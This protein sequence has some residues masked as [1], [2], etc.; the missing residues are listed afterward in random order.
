MQ[1]LVTITFDHLECVEESD[2]NAGHS[3]PYLWA[4]AVALQ[5]FAVHAS[6]TTSAEDHRV[7]IGREVKKEDVV[8]IETATSQISM[9][10]EHFE[11][12]SAIALVSTILEEDRSSDEAMERG[13]RAYQAQLELELTS[14]LFL[15]LT[16][17]QLVIAALEGALVTTIA[18]GDAAKIKAEQTALDKKR[19]K[20]QKVIDGVGE[21]VGNKVKSAV[22]SF[23]SL[24][25]DDNIASGFMTFNQTGP[26]LQ[27]IPIA[28][29]T[30]SVVHKKGN[31]HY[32]VHGHLT[33][34]G[35]R[36]SRPE[37]CQREAENLHTAQTRLAQAQ[38]EMT[39]LQ[40]ALRSA[41]PAEKVVLGV[42]IEDQAIA[43]DAL[44]ESRAQAQQLLQVCRAHAHDL[45]T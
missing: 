32:I 17:K 9:R 45:Q 42:R 13:Y 44:V 20:L 27:R 10:F 39:S 6:A 7:R 31:N 14:A 22:G 25:P 34:Q 5:G 30:F 40:T 24:N 12:I 36:P 16:S 38:A 26:V 28:S 1:S 3:E 2:G 19:I 18:S 8:P 33:V 41:S 11:S 35:V 43:I 21:R 29:Q 15:D 37:V 4:R 23:D